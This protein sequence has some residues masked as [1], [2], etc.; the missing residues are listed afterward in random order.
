MHKGEFG[1]VVLLQRG[2]PLAERIQRSSGPGKFAQIA[3]HC[4]R[5]EIGRP[6][7]AFHYGLNILP[8]AYAFRLVRAFIL[9][10]CCLAR[11]RRGSGFRMLLG[12]SDAA[13]AA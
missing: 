13:R 10:C 5:F 8:H 11:S 12:A 7:S 3:D 4:Q 6:I 2:R 1:T 9:A